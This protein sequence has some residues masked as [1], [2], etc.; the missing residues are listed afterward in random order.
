MPKIMKNGVSLVDNRQTDTA[1][2][3]GEGVALFMYE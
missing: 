1:G 2:G 3:V